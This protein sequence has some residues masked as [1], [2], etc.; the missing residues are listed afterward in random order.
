[1][2]KKTIVNPKIYDAIK[3][4]VDD[5]FGSDGWNENLELAAAELRA[6]VAHVETCSHG[7][8]KCND[9]LWL[10]GKK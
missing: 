7:C 9:D 10:D 2:S 5:D 8:E 6:F 3:R 1:M 4:L